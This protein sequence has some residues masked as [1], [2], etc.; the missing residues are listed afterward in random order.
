MRRASI[1][2]S[3]ILSRDRYSLLLVF[4][5]LQGDLVKKL[6][7][8]ILSLEWADWSNFESKK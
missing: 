2:M 6:A 4:L 3:A 5:F 8:G 1:S 7:D